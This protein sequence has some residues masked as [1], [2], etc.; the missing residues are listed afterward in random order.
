[1]QAAWKHGRSIVDRL[2]YL[3]AFGI[4]LPVLAPAFDLLALYGVLFGD[5]L[6]AAA[7]WAA[8]LGVQALTGVVAFRLDH[9]RLESPWTL[10]LQQLAFRHLTYFVLDPGGGDRARDRWPGAPATA[11]RGRTGNGARRGRLG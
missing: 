11:G 2:P 5:R 9:E 4:A 8:L 7:A 1:M 6:E 3:A 10:P